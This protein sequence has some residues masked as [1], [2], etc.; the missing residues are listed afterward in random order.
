LFG[1]LHCRNFFVIL[2]EMLDRHYL[3][4]LELLVLLVVIRLQPSAYGVPVCHEVE[5]QT[6][7]HLS[8]GSVH[9]ALERLQDKGLITSTVGESTP[10]SG[11]KAKRF[12]HVTQNGLTRMRETRKTLNRLCAGIPEMEGA[13]L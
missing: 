8:L 3:G 2:E 12:F 7:R 1:A 9:A 11:G 6:G 5:R 4:E 13:W 10:E